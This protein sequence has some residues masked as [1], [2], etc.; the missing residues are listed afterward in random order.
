MNDLNILREQIDSIDAQIVKLLCERF[1]VVKN[2]AEYKKEHG[3][4]VLQKNREAE[5]LKNIAD[6]I[7]NTEISLIKENQAYKKYILEIYENILKTSK[8]S[9]Y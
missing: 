5:V 1:G 6:K 9:Q 8:S 2:V 4:E 7:D 3:L